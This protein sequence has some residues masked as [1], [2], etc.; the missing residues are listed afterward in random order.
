MGGQVPSR[1]MTH[2]TENWRLLQGTCEVPKEV[3]QEED[4]ER[5]SVHDGPGSP[6]MVIPSDSTSML[7]TLQSA[8][9]FRHC[10]HSSEADR[11]PLPLWG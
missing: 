10:G 9:H 8:N 11:K 1:E 4:R 2:G 5:H 6:G 7:R 3:T